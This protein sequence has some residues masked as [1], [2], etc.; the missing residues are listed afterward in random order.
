MQNFHL[1]HP[2][3]GPQRNFR[4]SSLSHYYQNLRSYCMFDLFYP[5]IVLA[6]VESM[7]KLSNMN[8]VYNPIRS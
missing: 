1:G 7:F 5:E 4:A 6:D 2:Q 3:N 8:I